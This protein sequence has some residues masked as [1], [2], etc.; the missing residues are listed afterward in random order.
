MSRGCYWLLALT[1]L[2]KEMP[3]TNFMEIS[4]F[5]G[6]EK[7]KKRNLSALKCERHLCSCLFI[8][9]TAR[10]G[11]GIAQFGP[12]ADGGEQRPRAIAGRWS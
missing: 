12:Q 10:G 4:H 3:I 11:A 8:S 6:G 1:R 7:K 9:K 2:Q 5:E